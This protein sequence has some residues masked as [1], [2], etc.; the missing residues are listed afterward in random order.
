MLQIPRSPHKRTKDS[1]TSPYL[2]LVRPKNLKVQKHPQKSGKHQ[3]RS[4]KSLSS[5]QTISFMSFRLKP[6]KASMSFV[7]CRLCNSDI[8]SSQSNTFSSSGKKI[9]IQK[10]K[11]NVDV[12]RGKKYE[13]AE[14]DSSL[15][16][17]FRLV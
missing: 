5:K 9:E 10:S 14:E 17:L 4:K 3:I 11:I 12:S 8:S 7:S 13:K 15:A 6:W 16:S 1:K 2:N